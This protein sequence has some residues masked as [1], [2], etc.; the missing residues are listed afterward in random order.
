M[1]PPP[2]SPSKLHPRDKVGLSGSECLL[3]SSTTPLAPAH[4]LFSGEVAPISGL[5]K[6]DL[7]SHPLEPPKRSMG[8]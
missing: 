1:R 4:I 6:H 3:V 7:V 8:W 2:R 5:Q